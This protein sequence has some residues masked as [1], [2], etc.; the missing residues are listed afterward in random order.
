MGNKKYI[1]ASH[2][3]ITERKHAENELRNINR[4]LRLTS[5]CNQEMVRATDES[6]LLQAIC[7]IAVEHGG[8][9]MAWVGFAEQD[10]T[11]SVRPAAHAGF[12]D[13]YLDA[14]NITWADA[15]RGSRAHRQGHPAP[16]RRR[17]PATFPPNRILNPGARR[18]SSV[19]MPRPSPC[20]CWAK[21]AASER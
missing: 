12:D 6:A 15:K 18:P 4:A 17:G 5:L 8:Y 7:K 13:G 14:A 11:K 16:A 9:R 19:A 21:A 10:E 20:R 1:L 2:R 3:D